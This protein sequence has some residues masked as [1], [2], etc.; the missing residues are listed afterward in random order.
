MAVDEPAEESLLHRPAAEGVEISGQRVGGLLVR[1][2]DAEAETF[3][4]E[5][6]GRVLNEGDEVVEPEP[7]DDL[8]HKPLGPIVEVVGAVIVDRPSGVEMH[9]VER[10]GPIRPQPARSEVL[11]AKSLKGVGGGERV[12]PFGTDHLRQRVL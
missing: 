2:G 6:F 12:E 1:L 11:G 3:P 4:H 5:P 9:G 8:G 7:V 10:P